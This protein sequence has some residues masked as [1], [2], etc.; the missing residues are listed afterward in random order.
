MHSISR[1]C[2]LRGVIKGSLTFARPAFPLT[3]WSLDGTRTPWACSPGFAPRQAGPA[4]RTPEQGTGIK[5]SPGAIRPASSHRTSFRKLTQRCATSRRTTG[6]DITVCHFPPGTSKWNKIEHRLFCQISLAWRGRPLT[7]YDVIINTIAA[8]KTRTGLTATA[9]L[10]HNPCPTGT[11]I[12][13]RQMKDLEDRCL[14]RHDFRGEWNY[15]LLAAPRPAPAPNPPKAAPARLCSQD[16]L[17]HPALTG[18][19]PDAVNALAAALQVPFGARR[20]QDNYIRRGRARVNAEGAG[21]PPALDLQDHL[22]AT[23]IRCHLHPPVHVIAAIPGP[24]HSTV[25]HAISRTAALLADT[26]LPPAAPPPGIR[27]RTLED[28]REYAARHGITITGPPQP[29]PPQKP[30]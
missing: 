14:A 30:H 20:E 22:P 10:D 12:S 1:S 9:V 28:L 13:D 5:H 23:L 15:T 2:P 8:V 24:H 4:R 16:T 18:M 29:T 26:R 3:C 25:G 27:L 11:Q 6:L 17:N 7:S 19:A 21:K